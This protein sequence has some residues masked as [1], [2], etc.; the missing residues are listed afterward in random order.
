MYGKHSISLLCN[1]CTGEECVFDACDVC[2]HRSSDWFHQHRRCK[3]HLV[4]FAQSEGQIEDGLANSTPVLLVQGLLTPYVA[5]GRL[6]RCRFYVVALICDGL[7]S[8]RRLFQ[9]H[10]QSTHREVN[11]VPNPYSEGWP[12]TSF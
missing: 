9:L 4:A 1:V 8:N 2:S 11:K 12:F 6:E 3:L 10:D 7:A 5:V